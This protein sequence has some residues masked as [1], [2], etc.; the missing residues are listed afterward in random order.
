V[1]KFLSAKKERVVMD[2]LGIAGALLVCAI[3]VA[4]FDIAEDRWETL[5][6]AAPKPNPSR[7][8]GRLLYDPV[9]NAVLL[10]AAVNSR[11]QTWAYRYK[12]S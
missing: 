10:I 7:C 11:A 3:Q 5:S 2:R 1:K 12:I 4:A 8:Y 6:P 9:D